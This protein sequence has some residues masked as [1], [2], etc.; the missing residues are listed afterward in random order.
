MN[1]I[2]KNKIT[3]AEKIIRQAFAQNV[4]PG[5]NNLLYS[6]CGHPEE[7]KILTTFT[8]KNWQD[9]SLKCLDSYIYY[10]CSFSKNALHYYLP[11]FMIIT[12]NY[13]N[14]QKADDIICDTLLTLKPS[15]RKHNF[16]IRPKWIEQTVI[17]LT[18]EQMEAIKLF[19]ETIVDVYD[20]DW[21]IEALE[22]FWKNPSY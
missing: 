19:L 7:I 5:N 11:A 12:L 6:Q 4:Y 3:H 13:Y 16:G 2:K 8:N 20:D 21:A 22:N 10:L 14:D 17:G 1:R 18:Q 9:I 15:I